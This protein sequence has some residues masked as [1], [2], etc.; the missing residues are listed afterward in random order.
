MRRSEISWKRVI[1]T[2][3]LGCLFS[4]CGTAIAEQRSSIPDVH[5]FFSAKLSTSM[6]SNL[7]PGNIPWSNVRQFELLC[8]GGECFLEILSIATD[9]CD[10]TSKPTGPETSGVNHDLVS[11]YIAGT[12]ELHVEVVG[13][14]AL[15]LR[16]RDLMLW[17]PTEESIA[18]TY[19]DKYPRPEGA[20]PNST[21]IATQ[22]SGSA[23]GL[24]AAAK[25]PQA[26]IYEPLTSPMSCTV[27]FWPIGQ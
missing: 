8:F 11:N 4:A 21:K 16:F 19:V 27:V 10:G 23:T 2:T 18:I 6:A 12:D 15:L 7:V 13:K 24:Q 5:V 14:N 17:G 3:I 26:A 20:A 25:K 22:V 9:Y 1:Q